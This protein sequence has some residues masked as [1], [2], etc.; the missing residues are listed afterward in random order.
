MARRMTATADM[1][2]AMEQRSHAAAIVAEAQASE[3]AESLAT[4]RGI[5]E[6][7]ALAHDRGEEVEEA[8]RG[9]VRVLTRDGLLWLIQKGRLNAAQRSAAER[10]RRDYAIVHLVG[11]G[12]CLGGDGGAAATGSTD[13]AIVMKLEAARRLERVRKEALH[14]DERLVTIVDEV[15]GRGRT[16]RECAKGSKPLAE[17][18]EAELC[19]ALRL[20]A[21]WYG[22][23]G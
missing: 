15:V 9:P 18:L 2:R 10:F 23:A 22:V 17:M 6:Q 21:A 19:V 20:L 5:A 8:Q 13:N 4:S 14:R 12:S 7:V 1:A 11:V 3:R 16:I